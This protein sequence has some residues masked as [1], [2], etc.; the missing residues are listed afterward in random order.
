[1]FWDV[2]LFI[3][4]AS[5]QFIRL[6]VGEDR[7]I[8]LLTLIVHGRHHMT[9]ESDREQAGKILC[10]I[11]QSLPKKLLVS[12]IRIGEGDREMAS[13]VSTTVASLVS[14]PDVKGMTMP[15]VTKYMLKFKL[16]V[17]IVWACL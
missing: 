1:M 12:L 5:P 17:T 8:S 9:H 4:R 15:R 3:C 10:L 13:C 6:L 11:A 14:S 2:L 16:A 7:P